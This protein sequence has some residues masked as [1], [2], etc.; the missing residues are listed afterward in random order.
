MGT[1]RK[2]RPVLRQIPSPTRSNT[3]WTTD[4]EQ[5][6]AG[7][8]MT[9]TMKQCLRKTKILDTLGLPTLLLRDFGNFHLNST[10]RNKPSAYLLANGLVLIPYKGDGGDDG[11]HHY[12]RL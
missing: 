1:H 12:D 10:F 9:G 7:L 6:E 3:V 4:E 2:R 8:G 5:A 11:T